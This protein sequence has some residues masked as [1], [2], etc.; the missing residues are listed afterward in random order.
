MDVTPCGRNEG[1]VRCRGLTFFTGDY[2]KNGDTHL[3]RAKQDKPDTKRL[4]QDRNSIRCDV[5]DEL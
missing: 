2:S 3:G 5:L 1:G 4:N